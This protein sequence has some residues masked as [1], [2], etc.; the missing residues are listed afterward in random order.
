M[1]K[2]ITTNTEEILS[3][4]KEIRSLYITNKN[5]NKAY[6]KK[7]YYNFYNE[8]PKLFEL[9]CNPEISLTYLEFMC[10]QIKK[11]QQGVVSEYESS[12]IVGNKLAKDF[13]YPKLDMS[14]EPNI[15]PN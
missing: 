11:I 10:N 8:Y 7:K 3:N 13:V 6:L 9:S 15:K 4:V 5:N 2:K 1:S 14:K 12:G